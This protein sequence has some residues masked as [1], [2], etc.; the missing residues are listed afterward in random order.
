MEISNAP[1]P[2]AAWDAVRLC[3]KYYTSD[4]FLAT[5]WT[6]LV[7]RCTRSLLV[8]LRFASAESAS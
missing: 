8:R 6:F 3:T 1:L 7:L 4:G 2:P 5:L